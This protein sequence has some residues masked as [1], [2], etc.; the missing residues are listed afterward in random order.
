MKR[1]LKIVAVPIGIVVFL[2][3]AAIVA[4]NISPKPVA[5]LTNWQ[6]SKG[7][8][9]PAIFPRGYSELSQ[10]VSVQKDLVY[11]SKFASN[12]LDVFSP[13]NT[14]GPV[15]TILWV[16]GGGF[17]GGDKSDIEKWATIIAAEGYTVISINYALAPEANY[18]TPIIQTGEAYEFLKQNPGR[19]PAA[20]LKSL[21]VGGDSA[22]AQIASQF[23]ALQTNPDLARSMQME[24]V[25]PK[26]DLIGVILYCGPYD[27]RGLHDSGTSLGRF[28]VWQM[29]W[30]Y[31]GVR[32]WRDVP[33]ASQASTNTNVTAA[34]PPT[35]ITDGN[36]ASFESDARKLESAL[37]EK[38]VY[39]DSLYYPIETGKFGHEYQFD[40]SIP[41]S[42][43]AYQRTLAFL[44]RVTDKK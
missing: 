13:K 18:P 11:P 5:W 38:S 30:S 43:E 2:V 33:Q 1:L 7:I 40:F 8:G 26:E 14:N 37:L 25:V 23:V 28:F 9:D 41:Q 12:G 6:F 24:A 36:S 44:R 29:G 21:I 17:V 42:M 19:F 20:D 10:K 15:P 31:F 27:L 22:G 32:D 4:V 35:F 3:A 34:F 16:H 39:V